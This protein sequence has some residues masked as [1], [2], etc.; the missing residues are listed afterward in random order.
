M[1]KCIILLLLPI[2]VGCSSALSDSTGITP[3][4]NQG[5]R[6]GLDNRWLWGS[7]N[8]HLN[9]EHSRIDI[10]PL[11]QAQTHYNVK[12]LLENGPCYNCIW[13][14]YLKNNGDST[15]NLGVALRHPYAGNDYFT[16]FD[17]R[18]I[19]YF[20]SHGCNAK[21]GWGCHFPLAEA[22]DPELLNKDGYCDIYAVEDSDQ[23]DPPLIRY[24]PGGKLGGGIT[25]G[26]YS[27]PPQLGVVN[28]FKYYHCSENRRYFSTSAVL[29]RDYH[30]YIPPG[31]WDFGYSIDACWTPPLKTPVTKVPDDFPI[32]AN[33]MENYR[34]DAE[35]TGEIDG[36]KPATLT[37][38]V[39]S[40]LGNDAP[41]YVIVKNY[42]M[43]QYGF[44]QTNGPPI[45][46][47]DH[48][49]WII[50]VPNMNKVE[51]GW[52]WL[53]V[54]STVKL[55]KYPVIPH[56]YEVHAA[57]GQFVKVHVVS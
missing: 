31:E 19:V 37:V 15:I 41:Y 49:R 50:D 26:Y 28:P 48:V 33:G 24:Q 42:D 5:I 54:S 25:W 23:G 34:L 14:A 47:G 21:D 17:V 2:F 44:I 55:D 13:I 35:L 18:G 45:D 27:N 16:G 46:M 56:G 43:F 40:H 39:Y 6:Q 9:A 4:V 29:V 7:Y 57:V 30:I 1:N 52:Y 36:D 12:T 3:N 51:P 38:D 53:L 11:R 8:F 22:G 20:P 32:W 10:S